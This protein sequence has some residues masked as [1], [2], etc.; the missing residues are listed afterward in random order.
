MITN[1]TLPKAKR[2]VE[3]NV[4]IRVLKFVEGVIT[5]RKWVGVL[6]RNLIKTAVVNAQSKRAINFAHKKNWRAELTVI[7][8]N[9]AS[10]HCVFELSVKVSALRM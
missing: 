2:E 4:K 6:T 3:M 5:M 9:Q 1:S 10:L 8:S 7:G